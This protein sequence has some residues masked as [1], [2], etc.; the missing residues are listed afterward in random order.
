[1]NTH[2]DKIQKPESK[3]VATHKKQKNGPATFQLMDKRS[4]AVTQRKL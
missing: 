4:E 3:S 2:A 1:M